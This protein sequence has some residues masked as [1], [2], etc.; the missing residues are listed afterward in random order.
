MT[1][2]ERYKKLSREGRTIEISFVLF[3][4]YMGL[5]FN[6]LGIIDTN[7]GLVDSDPVKK[8]IL[9]YSLDTFYGVDKKR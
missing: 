4:C 7:S 3:E 2:A 8:T 6:E 5:I 1:W 9:M